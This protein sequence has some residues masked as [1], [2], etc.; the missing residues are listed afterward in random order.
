LAPC[1]DAERLAAYLDGQLF[2]E[3]RE[4][5]EEHIAACGACATAV[6]DSLRF[7]TAEEPAPRELR[8]PARPT[9][10]AA[11]AAVLTL[12]TVPG[13]AWLA[14][15]VERAPW[16]RDARA[17]LIAATAKAR[18][19][20][21]RLTGGFRWTGSVETTRGLTSRSSQ[22]VPWEYYEAAAKVR[23]A[24]ASS[25]SAER[26]GALADAHLLTGDVDSA[27]TTLSRALAAE[28]SEPRLESDLAAAYIARGQRQSQAA[29]LAAAVE[30]A[31]AALAAKPELLEA[32]F[33]RALALQGLHLHAQAR[34]AWEEYLAAETDHDWA[35]EGRQ[36]LAELM[37]RE[38]EPQVDAADV[39]RRNAALD[40]R[41][42]GPLVA[43]H[44]FTARR[45]VELTLLPAWAEA[46]LNGPIDESRAPLAAAAAIARHYSA[47]TNDHRLHDQVEEVAAATGATVRRLAV[48]HRS[49]AAGETALAAFQVATARRELRHA[50]ASFPSTSV[51]KRRAEVELLVCDYAE[52]GATDAT[53]AAFDVRERMAGADLATHAR[54]SWMRG[55]IATDRGWAAAA[56]RHFTSALSLHQRL[57]ETEP[58]GWLHYLLSE[59]HANTGDHRTAWQHRAAALALVPKLQDPKRRYQILTSSAISSLLGGRPWLAEALLDEVEQADLPLQP[60]ER[61]E[62]QLWRA[63]LHRQLGRNSAAEEEVARAALAVHSL[64]DP[65]L[66]RRLGAELAAIRGATASTPRLAVAALSRA[67]DVFAAL[68]AESRL[69]GL[70]LQRARAY[71]TAGDVA[72]AERDLRRGIALLESQPLLAPADDVWLARLDDGSGLYDEMIRLELDRKRPDSAFAWSERG[73][74]RELQSSAVGAGRAVSMGSVAQGLTRGTALVSFAMLQER[75]VAWRFDERGARVIELPEARSRVSGAIAVLD[76]DLAAR[77]WSL[78]TAEAAKLLYHALIEPLQIDASTRRLVIVPDKELHAVPFAALLGDRGYLIQQREVEVAPGV[79]SYMRARE[80]WRELSGDDPSVFAVGDP[81]LAGRQFQDI[82][83]LPGAAIEARRVAGFYPAA[84]LVVGRQATRESVVKAVGQ[85]TIV[86]L[87]THALVDD[88]Y[89][90]HSA[91]ALADAHDNVHGSLLRADEIRSLDLA[92]TRTVVLAACGGAPDPLAAS[93]AGR[94]SLPRAFLA[95]GVPTVVASLWPIGDR[96]SIELLTRVHAQLST[97]AEPALALRRAQ[98]ALLASGDDSLRS[99]AT[100]ALFQALGG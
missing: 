85:H 4:R 58:T 35:A 70:L 17:P 42:L 56:L 20:A 25:P 12:V 100:W 74:D 66:R 13:V 53:I 5:L 11:A 6:A 61:A 63:R 59:A 37:A 72:A 88:S 79:A 92:G 9:R 51:G 65:A 50:L 31:S 10:W 78:R 96:R 64:E 91:L 19:L 36:H 7:H 2:P 93:V 80:R 77:E 69:P 52:T 48:A 83:R 82:Q 14:T 28:P 24:A 55:L 40:G 32:R 62:L 47:Q 90:A 81:E 44:R 29:D 98:L 57:G 49:L 76:A 87:A 94:L 75:L 27:L 3:Q 16:Q 41:S 30:T 15:D 21:P 8:F 71:R 1:P 73:K 95:S 46:V 84:T 22:S 43:Q 23:R 89:P 33:N 18:P 45:L 99:P 26:L 38:A 86:H 34:R 67:L 97:G 54:I 60:F 68:K 39:L